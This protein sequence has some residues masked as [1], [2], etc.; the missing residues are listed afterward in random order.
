MNTLR[1]FELVILFSALAAGIF[2][3]VRAWL[4]SDAIPK[5]Y[6]S[7]S[8]GFNWGWEYDYEGAMQD[9]GKFGGEPRPWSAMKTGNRIILPLNQPLITEG[10]E[11]TYQ[12]IVDSDNF[13]LDVKILSLDTSVTYPQ[14]LS[15]S[16]AR[17]G[18]SID[19]KQF[20]LEKITPQYI[21]LSRFHTS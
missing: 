12:G 21:N 10:L 14:I 11:I 19:D 7:A 9:A 16:E 6:R 2:L 13:R 1:P 15:R 18:F 17:R 20:V 3:F 5:E 4:L 8:P